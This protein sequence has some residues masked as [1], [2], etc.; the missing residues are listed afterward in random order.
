MYNIEITLISLY[1]FIQTYIEKTDY[2]TISTINLV[3]IAGTTNYLFLTDKNFTIAYEFKESELSPIY[4]YTAKFMTA[5]ILFDIYYSLFPLKK[6]LLMH[7]GIMLGG[8]ITVR[9]YQLQHL[10]NLAMI[11]QTSSIF[12][13]FINESIICKYL[14]ASTFFIYRIC[15]FPYLTTRYAI[16]KQEEIFTY[17]P[18]AQTVVFTL[19]SSINILNAYWFRKIIKKIRREL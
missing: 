2:K 16:S 11:M 5:Y 17:P 9:L 4:L 8:I 10:I 12:L 19:V 3:L 14:F 13:T 6:D 18:T 15:I 1:A 7:A